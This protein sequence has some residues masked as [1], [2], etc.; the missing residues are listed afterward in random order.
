MP[1]LQEAANGL[2]RKCSHKN[3]RVLLNA[4]QPAVIR[5]NDLGIDVELSYRGGLREVK[6]KRPDIVTSSDSLHYCLQYDW[7]GDTLAVNGRYQVPPD[8]NARRFFRI[9]RVPAHNSAGN[10]FDLTFLGYQVVKKAMDA[11]KPGEMSRNRSYK[12]QT[13]RASLADG[14]R[15][16]KTA[17]SG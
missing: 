14:S 3:N 1:K 10:S 11:L 13:T 5:L 8:G 15:T 12:C 17:V 4:L 16:P 2:I 7:G 6:G 9:F